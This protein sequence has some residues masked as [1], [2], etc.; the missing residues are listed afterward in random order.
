M[1]HARRL[2]ACVHAVAA[3]GYFALMHAVLTATGFFPF[4]AILAANVAAELRGSR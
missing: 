2:I 3:R 4:L 1:Q